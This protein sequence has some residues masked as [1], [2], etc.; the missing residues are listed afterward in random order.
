MIDAPRPGISHA[1]H[2]P[3]PSCWVPSTGSIDRA[4][5]MQAQNLAG[6]WLAAGGEIGWLK[7]WI[8]PFLPRPALITPN[9]AM[10]ARCRK[11]YTWTYWDYPAPR[12]GREHQQSPSFSTTASNAASRLCSRQHTKVCV[13]FAHGKTPYTDVL[14]WHKLRG[15]AWSLHLRTAEPSGPGTELQVKDDEENLL[16]VITKPVR[17]STTVGW[18]S[19]SVL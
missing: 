5:E 1:T 15:V 3:F 13:V 7:G 19:L 4:A 17:S 16:D 14:I 12:P 10:A 9:L 2:T 11:P 18:P 6:S 8:Y